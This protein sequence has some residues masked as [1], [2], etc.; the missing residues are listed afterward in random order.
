[1]RKTGIVNEYIF[2]NS[3]Y[4]NDFNI[5]KSMS[6]GLALTI[7]DNIILYDDEHLY[8]TLA[9]LSKEQTS[10]DISTFPIWEIE[11]EYFNMLKNYFVN[12]LMSNTLFDNI[13]NFINVTKA[14]FLNDFIN[15][16]IMPKYKIDNI[17]FNTVYQDIINSFLNIN[18]YLTDTNNSI[19]IQYQVFQYKPIY[20]NSKIFNSGSY[21]YSKLTTKNSSFILSSNLKIKFKP[22]KV[23][24]KYTFGYNVAYNY[25]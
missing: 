6:N 23:V 16:N 1:M 21:Y 10:Y 20:I 25:S 15:I 22:S 7:P 3:K 12:L 17:S 8:S 11:C 18:Y 9:V 4:I 13:E 24:S 2:K 14:D 5:L 19:P